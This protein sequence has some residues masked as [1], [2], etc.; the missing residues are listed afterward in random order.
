MREGAS[1][2]YAEVFSPDPSNLYI[3]VYIGWRGESVQPWL[4][5]G[6]TA[7]SLANRHAA[8][9]HIASNTASDGM[10][11]VLLKLSSAAKMGDDPARFILIG[12]S[13]GGLIVG[14]IADDLFYRRIL[15]EEGRVNDSAASPACI[16]QFADL[17]VL[18]NPA[19]QWHPPSK[20]SRRMENDR[21]LPGRKR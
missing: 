19:D 11:E 20:L 1:Q 10:E 5:E 8:A 21:S 12:H 2:C 15:L 14:R 6:A 9:V 18:L 4:T 16:G 17:I 13:F 3:G 7:L